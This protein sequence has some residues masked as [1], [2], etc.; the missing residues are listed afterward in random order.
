MY[1]GFAYR[2][3]HAGTCLVRGSCLRRR[4]LGLRCRRR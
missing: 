1:G 2:C 3:T 4:A